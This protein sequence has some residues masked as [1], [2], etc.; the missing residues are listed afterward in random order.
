MLPRIDRDQVIVVHMT[1]DHNPDLLADRPPL[2]RQEIEDPT[3]AADAHLS[4]LNGAKYWDIYKEVV[5]LSFR[6]NGTNQ[7]FLLC[8]EIES[9]AVELDTA[10]RRVTRCL[11]EEALIQQAFGF[12]WECYG[13]ESNDGK[14][15]FYRILAGWET[16]RNVWPILA[17]RALKY[18]VKAPSAMLTDPERRWPTVYGLVDLSTIYSQ[19]GSNPK[20]MP[21]LG[22]VLRYWGFGEDNM[23]PRMAKIRDCICTDPMSVIN[24]VE[25]YLLGMDAAVQHYYQVPEPVFSELTGVPVPPAMP[26]EFIGER[27]YESKS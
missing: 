2:M 1:V 6:W 15:T 13:G 20:F 16:H 9:G 7:H 23:R 25:P 21:S 22:D 17:N 27:T 18:R 4:I 11:S 10:T 26:V 19:A 5:Q 14:T 24:W 3:A 12:L 8:D